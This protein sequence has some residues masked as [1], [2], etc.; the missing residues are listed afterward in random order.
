MAVLAQRERIEVSKGDVHMPL[1]DLFWT[2]L[3][4]FLFFAWLML[5]FRVFGDIFR[6]DDMGGGAKT[7]WTIF[8]ILV[9]LLGV[10]IYVMARGGGMAERD[11]RQAQAAEQATQQYIRAAAGST[12][13]ADELAKLADLRDKGILTADE[14]ESQKQALLV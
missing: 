9:P 8:V 5:L 11:L 14:F 6:S 12:S 3:M 4:F 1:L 10:F 2:M 7:L 13:S